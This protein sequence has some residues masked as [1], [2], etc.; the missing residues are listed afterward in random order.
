[1]GRYSRKISLAQGNLWAYIYMCETDHYFRYSIL[2]LLA[3][4]FAMLSRRCAVR[5]KKKHYIVYKPELGNEFVNACRHATKYVLFIL[6]PE[7][8]NI[9]ILCSHKPKYIYIRKLTNAF[10]IKIVLQHKTNS[11]ELFISSSL[12]VC[13]YMF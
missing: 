4:M 9:I 13:L 10:C 7:L 2:L 12:L 11:N 3:F 8:S 1:M 6:K 5:L